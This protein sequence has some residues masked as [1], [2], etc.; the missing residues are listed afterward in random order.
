MTAP[1]GYGKSTLLRQLVRQRPNTYLFSLTAAD[2]DL[3]FLHERL[4]PVL[5]A[6]ATLLLDD[7]H[8]IAGSSDVSDW[9]LQQLGQPHLRVVLSTRTHPQWLPTSLLAEKAIHPVAVESL[10]FSATEA[11]V[12]FPPAR[13][14]SKDL[15]GWLQ[16]LNGWPLGL[17]LLAQLAETITRLPETEQQIFHYLATDVFSTLPPYLQVFLQRTAVP[18]QFNDDL[19]ARLMED[20]AQGVNL[21][22]EIMRRNLFLEPADEPGWFR[23]HD[24]IRDFLLHWKNF[25]ARPWFQRCIHYFQEQ[26]Q[27]LA[28]IEHALAGNLQDEAAQAI[29]ALPLDHIYERDLYRTYQRWVEGLDAAIRDRYPALY[30]YLG[31]FLH[32]LPNESATSHTYVQRALALAEASGEREVVTT[33]RLQLVSFAL[34]EHGAT[35]EIVEK[36]KQLRQEPDTSDKMRVRIQ[37]LLAQAL[38]ALARFQEAQNA[39]EEG[40]ALAEQKEFDQ[41]IWSHRRGLALYVLTPLGRFQRAEALFARVLA[42]FADN[43]SWC[44]ELQQNVCDLYLAQG[45][46]ERLTDSLAYIDELTGLL[47]TNVAHNQLWTHYFRAQLAIA[48]K[49]YQR[50]EDHLDQ[51]TPL[52]ENYPMGLLC[53]GIARLWL[54]RRQG[55]DASATAEALLA[56]AL[57]TPLYRT[58]LAFE[59][60]IARTLVSAEQPSAALHPETHNLIRWRCRAELVRLR[61]LLALICWRVESPRWRRHVC[62]ALYALKTYWGYEPLLTQRDPDLGAH[63]WPLVLLAGYDPAQAQT[64]L[65]DIGDPRPALAMLSHPDSLVVRSAAQAIAACGQEESI[66]LLAQMKV[67]DEGVKAALSHAIAHLESLPPP[68]LTVQLLGKF[69]LQRAA[70]PIHSEAWHRPIVQKLFQYFCLHRSQFLTKDQILDDLW[71]D[72]DPDRAWSTFRTVYSRLRLVLEPYVQSRGLN[73]YV[74]LDGDTYHFDPLD[75]VWVDIEAFER[76]IDSVLS[77]AHNTDIPPLPASFLSALSSYAPLL[78]EYPYEEWLLAPRQRLTDRYI[79]GC[80]YAAQAFLVHG[81]AVQAQRWAQRTVEQAPWLEEGYQALIRALARQKQRSQALR[82]YVDAVTSLR[83]ELDVS[84]SPQTEWLAERLRQGEAI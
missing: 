24:L 84:P 16:R 58:L 50:A 2:A 13:R 27:P 60:D 67:N 75:V 23:Y 9:L 38:S 7:V 57:D 3:T 76:T 31:H 53:Q 49:A 39:W 63:F 32:F 12:L 64:A 48:H 56:Q 34:H 35:P 42:H 69:H 66:P 61:A 40:M 81:D 6:P 55:M 19:A 65:A 62:A 73:R 77:S 20:S 52:I 74:R 80:L 33:A 18:L 15:Q 22:Q 8:R 51:M 43:P 37:R 71:P 10:R 14:R 25:E 46:W 21:R 82:V 28:A 70:T 59:A 5:T 44:Y 29:L 78:P 68:S 41:E 30:L 83:R 36:L 26:G 17:S 54:A 47:E 1:A 11:T 4:A 72:T 45:D 79:D